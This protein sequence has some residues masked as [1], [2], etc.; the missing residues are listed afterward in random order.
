ML[1]TAG[2]RRTHG[3]GGRRV[4]RA[5]VTRYAPPAAPGAALRG[6]LR[7]TTGQPLGV[8][9]VAGAATACARG[10]CSSDRQTNRSKR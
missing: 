6:R 7:P 1:A 5:I 4:V 8:I 10:F 2:R 3:D 9:R